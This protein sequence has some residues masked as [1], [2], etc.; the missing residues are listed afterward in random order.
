MGYSCQLCYSPGYTRFLAGEVRLKLLGA[1]KSLESLL[2]VLPKVG[3]DHGEVRK[4]E[5]GYRDKILK[6]TGQVMEFTKEMDVISTSGLTKLA[7]SYASNWSDLVSDAVS[8]LEEWLQTSDED[9]DE[10]EDD[11]FGASSSHC[12]PNLK[13]LATKSLEL[14][15][16]IKLLYPPIKK[17]RIAR[18]PNVTSETSVDSL[19][20]PEICER[21]DKLLDSCKH[22]SEKVDEVAEALYEAETEDDDEE[23]DDD[24]AEYSDSAD[25]NGKANTEVETKNENLVRKRMREL[26]ALSKEVLDAVRLNWEGQEDEFT[27]WS[28]KWM[29]KLDEIDV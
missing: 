7:T 12:P 3:A 4:E 20:S 9:A 8:E 24:E 27:T 10:K 5:D 26:K 15:K 18:F 29:V 11:I 14:C 2:V 13:P 22:L 23:E 19:P 25:A 17:R 21:F 1:M 28:G 16:A 6:S